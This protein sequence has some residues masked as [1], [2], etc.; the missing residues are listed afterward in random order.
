[1][2]AFGYKRKQYTIDVKGK[3]VFRKGIVKIEQVE[4]DDW[5]KIK[6]V[7]INQGAKVIKRYALCSCV[8]LTAVSLPSTLV[9]IG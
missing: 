5:P 9:K 2:S 1:M 6:K 8:E 4:K 7:V 3:L